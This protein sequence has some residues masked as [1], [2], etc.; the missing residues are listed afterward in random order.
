MQKFSF[1]TYLRQNA[2][3]II[4]QVLRW[5][6]MVFGL[7]LAGI[8][9]LIFVAASVIVWDILFQYGQA[10]AKHTQ[11][12]RALT[13]RQ[14]FNEELTGVSLA[15][16]L[17]GLFLSIFCMLGKFPW[18]VLQG[19]VVVLLG[20]ICYYHG[21]FSGINKGWASGLFAKIADLL[22]LSNRNKSESPK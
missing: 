14:F 4:A 11:E 7:W 20:L 22:H 5:S 1:L 9:E 3:V 21:R 12:P 16:V 17:T 15:V 2:D 18:A 10:Q 13:L 8:S 19:F 6:A